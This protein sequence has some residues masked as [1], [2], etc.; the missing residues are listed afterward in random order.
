MCKLKNLI[1]AEIIMPGQDIVPEQ[2]PV[3]QSIVS[4]TKSVG[5]NS[6]SHMLGIKSSLLICF[7]LIIVRSYDRVFAY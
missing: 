5:N 2:G 7:C 1:D 3:A 6:L 4:L